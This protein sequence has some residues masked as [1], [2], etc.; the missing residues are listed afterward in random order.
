MALMVTTVTS[1][2]LKVTP[3]FLFTVQVI[4]CIPLDNVAATAS[5]NMGL[6]I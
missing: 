2:T 6:G 3:R 1:D 5:W 4:N